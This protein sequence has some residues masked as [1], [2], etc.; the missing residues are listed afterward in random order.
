[1][2]TACHISVA[3]Q[4]VVSRNVPPLDPAVLSVTQIRAGDA[5]NIIPSTAVLSG[6]VRALRRE[7]MDMMEEA[8]RR[9]VQGTASAFG[10]TA[11]MD[12]RL[13]FAPLMNAQ[14]EAR[15][16]VEAA[17][18]LDGDDNVNDR[19]LPAA[20]S[21]DFS[22]MLEKVPGAYIHLGNGEDIPQVHTVTYDF[23]DGAIPYGSALFARIVERRLGKDA[24]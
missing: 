19:E 12:Y 13:I 1:V 9:V 7:T 17:R 20:A 16:L 22:F 15:E 5:Y 2:L 4:S 11:E 10:A 18:E 3:L 8:M 14:N 24:A 21:E 23:N 6:T